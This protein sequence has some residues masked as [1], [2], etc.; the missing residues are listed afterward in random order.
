MQKV[1]IS[2]LFVRGVKQNSRLL[3]SLLNGTS[4]AMW[5]PEFADF[6]RQKPG[7]LAQEVEAAQLGRVRERPGG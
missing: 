7:G 3:L 2:T 5:N 1:L 6:S 4:F